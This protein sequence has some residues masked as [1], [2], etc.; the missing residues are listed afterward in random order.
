MSLLYQVSV[1]RMRDAL[2]H[3]LRAVDAAHL[4]HVAISSSLLRRVTEDKERIGL[5]RLRHRTHMRRATTVSRW[6]RIALTLRFWKVHASRSLAYRRSDAV[7]VSASLLCWLRRWASSAARRVDVDWLRTGAAFGHLRLACTRAVG[8]WRLQTRSAA[9][10]AEIESQLSSDSLV[11]VGGPIGLRVRRVSNV[12][13]LFGPFLSWRS[14]A[15]LRRAEA[16]VCRWGD[17]V[18]LR[19]GLAHFRLVA[20]TAQLVVAACVGQERSVLLGA[21]IQLLLAAR[22]GRAALQLT[23][24]AHAFHTRRVKARA[25]ARLWLSHQLAQLAEQKLAAGW[26][27]TLDACIL[28]CMQRWRRRASRRRQSRMVL[29]VAAI[30]HARATLLR[31]TWTFWRRCRERQGALEAEAT[32]HGLLTFR[33]TYL[34]L[35]HWRAASNGE[36]WRVTDERCATARA[37]ATISSVRRALDFWHWSTTHRQLN[38]HVALL[39]AAFHAEQWAWCRWLDRG[40]VL[41]QLALGFVHLLQRVNVSRAMTLIRRWRTAAHTLKLA[42]SLRHFER[43][44]ALLHTVRRWRETSFAWFR[45]SRA[46]TAYPTSERLLCAA[47]ALWLQCASRRDGLRAAQLTLASTLGWRRQLHGA[48]HHWGAAARVEQDLKLTNLTALLA[49]GA[50]QRRL[51]VSQQRDAFF[52]WRQSCVVQL[53]PVLRQ[54]QRAGR[55]MALAS[56][57]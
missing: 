13:L 12:V 40:A 7:S 6:A 29:A 52:V 35:Q 42:V 9:R 34:A 18:G 30:S 44:S 2:L 10:F 4:Q 41:R 19:R 32:V 31:G 26:R 54:L 43:T 20:Q 36:W 5:R 33:R 55:R 17:R 24:A 53:P 23:P 56:S 25:L 48:L 1:R 47:Y 16:A 14:S 38:S 39:A 57:A 45:L 37:S 22:G 15:S 50:I 49:A 28:P 46:T 8:R 11:L 27:A 3:L 21:W 51:P